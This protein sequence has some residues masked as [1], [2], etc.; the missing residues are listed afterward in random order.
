MGKTIRTAVLFG[1]ALSASSLSTL[2]AIA[3][4]KVLEF[5]LEQQIKV[6]STVR[7]SI[8][9]FRRGNAG[10]TKQ[11]DTQLDRNR[12]LSEEEFGRLFQE[13]SVTQK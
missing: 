10:N 13:L 12:F 1:F 6:R 8:D 7:E 4:F 3:D 11:K 5:E 2:P 9:R